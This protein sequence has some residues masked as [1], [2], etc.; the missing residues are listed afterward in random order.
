MITKQQFIESLSAEIEIIRHLGTKITEDMLAYRPSEKQR[1]L[2][3][4]M[5]YLGHIFSTG[6]AV[7]IEGNTNR[8]MEIAQNAPVVTLENFDS[9]MN[10]QKE[11]VIEKLSALTDEQLVEVTDFFGGKAPRGIHMFNVMKWAVAYKMQLFLY[12]KANGNH[13]IST[14]NL[15]RG[16]DMAPKN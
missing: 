14:S 4:L 11:Y 1:T 6:V 8:Y 12:I 10:D 2:L 9:V 5:N 15:W 16:V 13:D 7:N 3:E